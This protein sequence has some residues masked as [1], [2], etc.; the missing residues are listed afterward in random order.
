[1]PR[2]G[3]SRW[4]ADRSHGMSV[5]GRGPA[6]FE[7]VRLGPGRRRVDPLMIGIVLVAIAMLL[8]LV[9]P[10]GD[11]GEGVAA[12]PSQSQQSPRPQASLT[13][14]VVAPDPPAWADV[15]SVIAP[16]TSWGI[17]S[18]LFG[19]TAD[20]SSP[21]SPVAA[22][23]YTEQWVA[24][25][26]VNGSGASASLTPGKASVVALGVTFPQGETPLA[27]RI[28]LVH[29]GDELE[30]MDARPI[31]D[32]PARGAYLFV[33]RALAGTPVRA[34]AP[35]RYRMDV[36]VG[37]GI[38]RINLRVAGT[39]GVV[40]APESWPE[41]RPATGAFDPTALD[42][43][44]IGPFA[45]GTRDL[46]VC[47]WDGRADALD[48]TAGPALDEIQAWLDVDPAADRRS[49]VARTY[50]P[51]AARIGVVLPSSATVR[52]ATVR[53]I[54]P[55]DADTDLAAATITGS[56]G[57]LTYVAFERP[58]AVAWRPGVYSMSIGWTDGDGAHKA[59]W[60][61]ELRPGPL[62][63]EPV[64][65]SATRV[66]ARYVGS[67]GVLLGTTQRDDGISD[68]NV[69]LLGI[70]PPNGTT[71]PGLGG[72]DLI[73][74]GATHVLGRPEVIGIVGAADPGLTP[75]AVRILYPFPD[76]R[77]LEVL[78]ASG[79]VPGLTLVVPVATAE[80]GG[81]ASYGFRAGVGQDAPGY[82]ICI[83]LPAS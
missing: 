47:C 5:D 70:E 80:F 19:S 21:A 12:V 24:A 9:K 40:P 2:A 63:P 30:W 78:T 46:S 77:R 22:Q 31:N 7:P 62:P 25:E 15:A 8:A 54:A 39:T 65:L 51:D 67:T 57:D 60:H 50:Q 75:V 71:Y 55:F 66:W 52:S 34:W 69:G 26:E 17:R 68:T 14:P 56:L 36:L 1:M 38:K 32:V 82:T 48:A 18:I 74:C 33:R 23:R 13:T 4:P 42:G 76:Q 3:S 29:A 27:V 73:G 28:W 35:G 6:D 53:G 10:W 11:G 45:E 72:S 44:A 49:F 59:V 41:V 16:R 64:L 37:G 79:S 81:P 83:G 61:V 58:D 20:R 43:A